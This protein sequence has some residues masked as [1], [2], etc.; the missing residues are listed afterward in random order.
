[1]EKTAEEVNWERLWGKKGASLVRRC[2][3]GL[4][5]SERERE[6]YPGDRHPRRI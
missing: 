1:V 3:H 2:P 6:R 5:R 4:N